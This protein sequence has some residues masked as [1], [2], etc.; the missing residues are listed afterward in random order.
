M[1]RIQILLFWGSWIQVCDSRI[2]HLVEEIVMGDVEDGY[3]AHRPT[4][5]CVNTCMSF[6]RDEVRWGEVDKSTNEESHMSFPFPSRHSVHDHHMAKQIPLLTHSVYNHLHH[7]S[8]SYHIT[9]H[10]ISSHSVD[11]LSAS[12]PQPLTP[13]LGILETRQTSKQVSEWVKERAVERAL[14]L[15]FP[16]DY[17]PCESLPKLSLDELESRGC[18]CVCMYALRRRWYQG[19]LFLSQGTLCLP[20]WKGVGYLSPHLV[21][22]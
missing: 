8:I 2:Y 20:V 3:A 18:V 16:N 22:W 11:T 9:S 19:Y 13:Y 7:P 17:A 10:L 14:Y 1:R 6:W 4:V 12:I 5:E 15:T 21:P